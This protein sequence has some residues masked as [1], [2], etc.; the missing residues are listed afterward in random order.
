MGWQRVR[1]DWMTFTSLSVIK[2]F[3]ILIWKLPLPAFTHGAFFNVT[4]F[5]MCL[6]GVLSLHCCMDSALVAA[7]RGYSLAVAHGFLFGGFSCCRAQAPEHRFSSCGPGLV[8]LRHVGPFWIRDWTPV[9]CICRRLL[10]HWA[11]REAHS[12]CLEGGAICTRVAD[13][14]RCMAETIT[15]L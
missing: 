11:T 3:L 2:V 12:W 15:I 6:S 4:F 13:S 14:C 9:S 5:P 10:Y 7:S 1:H 8:A